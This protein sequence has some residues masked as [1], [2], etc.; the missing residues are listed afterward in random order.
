MEIMKVD[1]IFSEKAAHGSFKFD[2]RV[3]E[4]FTDMIKRSVPGYENVILMISLLAEKFVTSN[5][6]CYDLGCSLG[7]A[8]ISMCQYLKADNC[9]IYAI[10]NSDAMIKGCKENI[11]RLKFDDV[12]VPC[13]ADI[14]DFSYSNASMIVLNFTLQFITPEKR[15]H[16]LQKLY[17]SMN[18]N[19]CLVLSEKITFDDDQTSELFIDIY[20]KFKMHNGYSKMEV[21]QKRNALENVLI[22]DTL[23]VHK[24]RL[25]NIGFRKVELWFQCFNFM[26]MVAFK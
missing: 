11:E 4:V 16:L 6:N 17:D 19:G 15:N 3:A 7:A 21:S 5:S 22:P 23:K 12:I 13:L 8:A 14:S 24:E 20:H 18:N 9:Q 10:D 2:E 26:S 1:D 25:L